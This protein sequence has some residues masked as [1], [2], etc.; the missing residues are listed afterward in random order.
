MSSLR[1]SQ[2]AHSTHRP[3]SALE[4]NGLWHLPSGVTCIPDQ[5]ADLQLRLYVIAH[6]GSAGHRSIS[7]TKTAVSQAFGWSTMSEDIALF[8]SSCI[9]CLS[10]RG[11]GKTPRPFGPALFG[12][13]PNDLVHVVPLR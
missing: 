12:T 10:S 13:K 11:G 6:T 5:D 7:A 1:A 3:T 8:V 2:D 4:Y 9:H